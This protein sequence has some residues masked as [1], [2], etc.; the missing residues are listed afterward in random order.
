MT[1]IRITGLALVGVLLVAAI[2]IP[3]PA[4]AGT[5]DKPEIADPSGDST[6]GKQSR[7]LTAAW[8]HDEQNDTFEINMTLSALE[9]YTAPGEIPNLPTTE[10]EVYFSVGESNFAVGC[11][12]PVHGPLGV[13]IQF[14][15][16]SVQYGNN[17]TTEI[18]LNT[19]TGQ[20]NVNARSIRW[21]VAKASLGNIT[22][23]T[24][25]TRTWA[26]V[27]NKNFG[28]SQ[29]RMEDRGPNM[30]YGLD[31]V[32]R[33]SAG[34]EI[35]DVLITADNITQPVKPNEPAEFKLSVHNRGTSTVNVDF[36][37][38]SLEKKGWTLEF[39]LDNVTL[40]PNVTRTVTIKVSCPRDAPN[41]TSVTVS[42]FG[43]VRAGSQNAT[44]N[45]VYLTAT[46]SFIPPAPPT[47][48]FLQKLLKWL[49][50]PTYKEFLYIWGLIGL[51]VALAAAGYG[52]GLMRRK[53]NRAA[54]IPKAPSPAPVK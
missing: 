6:S 8:F 24:H 14:D 13:S 33:G 41:R 16:R 52:Y 44:T 10:Y 19:L 36:F 22:A 25:L 28:D 4:N 29:R 21:T 27:Y 26:A 15:I 18:Q 49:T 1:V 38:S 46:V 7:D 23:G 9:S 39:G 30:G 48:N 12:V 50:N 31:Y 11:K 47:G 34:A 54:D 37:N 32:I 53:R 17:T 51:L 43:K 3:P 35:I 45:S 20:Y 40:L 5:A 42:V 2:L